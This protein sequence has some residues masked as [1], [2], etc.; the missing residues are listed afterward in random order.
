MTVT[1]SI[2]KCLLQGK[3]VGTITADNYNH[4]QQGTQARGQNG[5]R[6]N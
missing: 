4:I 3:E 1:S 2:N 5:A 6:M